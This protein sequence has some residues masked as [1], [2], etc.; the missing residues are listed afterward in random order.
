MHEEGF[1]RGEDATDKEDQY[2]PTKKNKSNKKK[3]K[4]IHEE[5]VL[6]ELSFEFSY[7]ARKAHLF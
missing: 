4:T 3:K 2:T 6:W 5:D 7:V 1:L